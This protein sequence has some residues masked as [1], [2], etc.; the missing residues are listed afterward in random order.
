M[1]G[2]DGED[3]DVDF[4]LLERDQAVLLR[5]LEKGGQL[6]ERRPLDV[7]LVG[8]GCRAMRQ[9]VSRVDGGRGQR[10]GFG[11]LG[12]GALD[13]KEKS[14]AKDGIDVD[15]RLGRPTGR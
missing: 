11:V 3:E 9:D 1:V 14:G 5:R 10:K 4:G 15:G 2:V 7:N 6:L 13:R 8:R 12:K